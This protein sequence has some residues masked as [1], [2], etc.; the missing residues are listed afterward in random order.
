M[1]SERE[2][3]LEDDFINEPYE[4]PECGVS[5]I[6]PLGSLCD[7]CGFSDDI[8]DWEELHEEEDDE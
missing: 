5:H 4:C 8:D 7:W 6:D 3:S 1:T 2:W